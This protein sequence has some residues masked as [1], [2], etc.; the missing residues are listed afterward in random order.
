VGHPVRPAHA[1][2]TGARFAYT[3]DGGAHDKIAAPATQD[4]P[5]HFTVGKSY[6]DA[7]AAARKATGEREAVSIAAGEIRETRPWPWCRIFAFM[8][9]TLSAAAGEAFI[10]AAAEAVKRDV[11]LVALHAHSGRRT[12]CRRARLGPD[13]DGSRDPVHRQDLKR[14]R[15]ALCRGADRSDHRRRH[16]LVMACW[17]TSI[18]PSGAH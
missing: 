18:W 10:A 4:D 17:A 6:R 13:A 3:F 2:R 1:H 15:P 14:A 5:L 9:G 7:L 12:Q 11:P 16:R 8:A